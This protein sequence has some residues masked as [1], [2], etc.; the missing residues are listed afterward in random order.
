MGTGGVVEVKG[1]GNSGISGRL[2][3]SSYNVGYLIN[4]LV[5]SLSM[6]KQSHWVSSCATCQPRCTINFTELTTRCH[7][8]V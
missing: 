4:M 5:D 7:S 2:L 3:I 6:V 1:G 8:H